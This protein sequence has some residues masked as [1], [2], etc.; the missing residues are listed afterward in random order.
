MVHH[1]QE[2]IKECFSRRDVLRGVV[3][4][5]LTLGLEGCTQSLSF[6]LTPT[7]VL[8]TRLLN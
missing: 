5:L 1:Y 2:Q 3:G 6:W 8:T 4:V 7:P